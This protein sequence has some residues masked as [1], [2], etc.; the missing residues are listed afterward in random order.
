MAS[1]KTTT[2]GFSEPSTPLTDLPGKTQPSPAP[3]AA[4]ANALQIAL[5]RIKE[6][7]SSMEKM[8]TQQEQ[9]QPIRRDLNREL[10]LATEHDDGEFEDAGEDP[11]DMICNACGKKVS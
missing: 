11:S 6:L 10:S 3:A 5:A 8:K 4:D 7:E 2:S 9:A 1:L